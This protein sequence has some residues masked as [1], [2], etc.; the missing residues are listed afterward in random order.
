ML[1][2][3]TPFLLAN[4]GSTLIALITAMPLFEWQISEINTDFPPEFHI[5]PFW[6]TKPWESLKSDLYVLDQVKRNGNGCSPRQLTYVV[7]RSQNAER[8][9]EIAMDVYQ[10]VTR[11]LIFFE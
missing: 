5:S 3:F 10:G 8:L 11:W 4:L 1:R 9:E 6:T 7:H 2:N